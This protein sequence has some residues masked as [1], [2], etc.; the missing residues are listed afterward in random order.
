MAFKKL[1]ASIFLTTLFLPLVAYAAPSTFATVIDTVISYLNRILF[2]MM[3]IAVVI[4]VWYVIQYF[5]KPNENRKDAGSYVMYSVIGFFVI[6]S[7]WGIVNI[8]Q[9]TFGLQNDSNRSQAWGSFSSLLPDNGSS[10]SPFD[11]QTNVTGSFY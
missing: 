5:I 10:G 1:S 6:L 9:N 4:F 7:F 3:G 2:L 11:S 8:L